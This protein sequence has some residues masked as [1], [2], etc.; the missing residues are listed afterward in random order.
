MH[1]GLTVGRF[2]PK[3]VASYC[4]FRELLHFPYTVCKF[5]V[6]CVDAGGMHGGLT[7]GRLSV[8]SRTVHNDT[9]YVE[10]TVDTVPYHIV[11]IY[12]STVY[13]IYTCSDVIDFLLRAW[14]Y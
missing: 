14:I 8:R 7:V 2:P 5:L 11:N 4:I 1:G 12:S 9:F 6:S 13:I 3:E 10:P